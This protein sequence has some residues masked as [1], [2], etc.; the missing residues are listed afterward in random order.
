MVTAS[1]RR[2]GHRP[3]SA[4]APA[5][6][7]ERLPRI[8]LAV[9]LG[10]ATAAVA[11]F[12]AAAF[13]TAALAADCFA[14]QPACPYVSNS[15]IGQRGGGVLRFP[16]AV[17][18][19]PDGSIYVGDQSSSVV[20]VFTPDGTF[21]REVG[22]AGRRPGELGAVGA[23][24]VA[25]DNT[26]FVAEGTNRIDRFDA[27]G[28]LIGSF[29]HGGDGVGEFHF[30][31]GGG[32]DAPAG[33]GLAIS[34]NLLFVSDSYNDRI[35][36]FNLDG[37]GG[38][39]IVSPGTLAYPRGLAVRNTRLLVADDKNHRIAVF[40]TGGRLLRTFARGP[41]SEGGQL[42][43][44]F[45]I[46]VDGP[47]RVFVADDLNHRVVRFG[48][49]SAYRYEA[50]WGSYGSSPGKLAYPRAIAVDPEGTLFVA[51]T[52]N[53]RIDVFDR[54]GELKRSFGASG[55][56]TGQF[57]APL[58]IGVDASGVR[59]VADSVNGRVQLLH[60]DGSIAAVWG[61]PAP[62]PT[63]LPNPVDVAFDAAGTA[64]VLD[65]RRSRIIV[66]DRSTGLPRRSI[67]SKGS[68]PGRL[69][70]PSAL[71]ITPGGTIYVADTGNKRIARFTTSGDY[72]GSRTNAGS[73]VGVA[74]TP[75]GSRVYV[76]DRRYIRVLDA[77]GDEV[78]EFGGL[79]R[80]LGKL[81]APAQIAL[82]AAGNLWVADKGNNRIQQFG[83]NGER[84]GTFGTRGTAPGQFINP[85]GV[86]VDCHGTLT[87]SDSQNNRVQQFAL[88]A[89]TAAPCGALGAL[90]NPPPPKLPT[91]PLPLGPDVRVK[92]LRS[93]ELFATRNL[94]L[95]VRCDTICDVTV[96]GK[97]AE[98]TKPSRRKR[99]ASASLGHA[100]T[101]IAAGASKVVRVKLSGRQV[102]RLRRAMG[103][104]RGLSV[105]LQVTATAE[106]GEPTAL[107]RRLKARG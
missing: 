10:V 67:A 4:R 58:G 9:A 3:W 55:R 65:R 81:S 82:D 57:N 52:G 17:A 25:A 18:I 21:V 60:P 32:N 59:A 14:A 107:S 61:S 71:A 56:A 105:T 36:R 27:S 23:I 29:G 99:A 34:G 97:V 33:G 26:L 31:A 104:R 20:Q 63:I 43:A 19:G 24:A 83:P 85:T 50:R 80:K 48:P 76:N 73:V 53:D 40:D 87:V 38:A 102:A 78:A 44:P 75:D 49:K 93:S 5:R 100:G 39:E 7:P 64:Y 77:A 62:G 69:R 68:G 106:A 35:Q 6:R 79:G 94:P 88:A 74:V 30:G 16:Q 54:G 28:R 101:T 8:V 46:A 22:L 86:N 84:L 1:H 12:V 13:A 89:P 37:S 47:G 70:D 90:G 103:R 11:W 95:R 96:T 51:N 72:L 92:V 42:N 45:G 15:Q 91:L 2:A 98:R 41:G 66:F